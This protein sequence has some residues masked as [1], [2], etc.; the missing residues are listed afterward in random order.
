MKIAAGL[1][2]GALLLCLAGP[3][4]A[5]GFELYLLGGPVFAKLGGDADEFGRQ[6]T[7][8]LA[9]EFPGTSWTGDTKGRTG[10]DLGAGL[11]Y[12][13]N[14][15]VG[16]A[17]EARY[18]QRGGKWELK[19]TSGTGT[20]VTT[21]MKLDYLEIPLLLQ[22]TPQTEG[23]I[24]PMVVIGPVLGFRTSSK[25]DVEANDGSG[26]VD[27]GD[28][29]KSTYFA[30]L[31]GAGGKLQ[32]AEKVSVILQARFQL[33]FSNLID[34]PDLS[35]KPQDFSVHAGVSFALQ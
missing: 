32:A 33:G 6:L 14:G 16:G 17:L 24:R 12:T 31:V 22:V 3:A 20:S 28:G 34:D 30:G 11:S 26:S 19:E 35:F 21:T 25:F 9:D 18:V 27:I 29:M 7:Q 2:L 13:Q 23:K 4:A 1:V 10:F 8:E 15:V 5:A